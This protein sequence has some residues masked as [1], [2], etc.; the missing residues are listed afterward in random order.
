[1]KLQ[2][3]R[4]L[5]RCFPINIANVLRTPTFKNISE[6]LNSHLKCSFKS[7]IKKKYQFFSL[8]GLSFYV[9]H[10]TFIEVPLCEQTSSAEKFLVAR[11]IATHGILHYLCSADLSSIAQKMKFPI[12][13]F[14]S[15]CDQISSVLGIW[16]HLL[17][18][19]LMKN[20][21]FC[22]VCNIAIFHKNCCLLFQIVF[23]RNSYWSL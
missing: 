4:C 16:S 23:H 20:I 8:K 3:F 7:I 10:E 19:P 11:L 21:I 22:A 14:F 12:K 17:K 18:K 2:A 5:H 1:M 13:D 9:V 15:K 6:R